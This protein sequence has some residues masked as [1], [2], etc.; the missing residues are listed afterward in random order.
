MRFLF[1]LG[2]CAALT[3]AQTISKQSTN[4]PSAALMPLI[5]QGV[6]QTSSQV[7]TDALIDD[8][9][10]TGAVRMMERS[11]METILKEQGFQQSWCLRR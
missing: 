2:I 1:I 8:L 10:K 4:I 3:H 9:M 5:G 6:D 7:V 11:Q